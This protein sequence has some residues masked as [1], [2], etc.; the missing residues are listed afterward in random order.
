[1]ILSLA[2]CIGLEVIR[3]QERDVCTKQSTTNHSSA[4]TTGGSSV[5]TQSNSTKQREKRFAKM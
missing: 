3:I 5:E 2:A 1:M 4:C